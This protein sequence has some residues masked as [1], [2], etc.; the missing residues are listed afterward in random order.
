[1]SLD[2]KPDIFGIHQERQVIEEFNFFEAWV[3][4][5]RTSVFQIGERVRYEREDWFILR[6]W[7]PMGWQIQFRYD[8]C[9]D[10]EVKN[11]VVEGSLRKA[12]EWDEEEI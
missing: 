6:V 2:S 9:K 10:G 8:I 1:M 3:S 4:P 5:K 7:Y 12:N 11:L